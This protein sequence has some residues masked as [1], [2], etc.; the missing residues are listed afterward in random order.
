MGA[1]VAL[2]AVPAPRLALC[3][4]H[5]VQFPHLCEVV[6]ITC[7]ILN[8]EAEAQDVQSLAQGDSGELPSDPPLHGKPPLPLVHCALLPPAFQT[9]FR[10]PC[11]SFRI[12]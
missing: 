5:L 4:G 10:C 1:A 8:T 12:F 11:V 2:A 6:A 9:P 3:E 7:L